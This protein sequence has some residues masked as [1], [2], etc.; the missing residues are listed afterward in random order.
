MSA[1]S[2]VQSGFTQAS[3]LAFQTSQS[4]IRLINEALVTINNYVPEYPT[5]RVTGTSTGVSSGGT[6]DPAGKPPN[7]PTIRD[8]AFPT[9]PSLGAL[10]N[11]DIEFDEQVPTLRIPSF[12]YRTPAEIDPFTEAFPTVDV[13]FTSVEAP[14][15][16]Y[17]DK[18][19][20]VTID[21]D[22]PIDPINVPDLILTKPVYDNQLTTD[23][24]IEFDAGWARIPHDLGN[25]ALSW[26]EKMF[27]GLTELFSLLKTRCSATLDGSETA[28]TDAFD[29]RLFDS[30]HT[31]IREDIDARRVALNDASRASGWDMPGAVRWAGE[32]SIDDTLL[33]ALNVAAREVYLKR[34][35]RELQHLQFVMGL[36][37][38]LFQS[39]TALFETAVGL[40]LRAFDSA[41]KFAD[42]STGFA[43]RVYELKQRELEAQIALMNAEITAFEALLKAQLAKVEVVK[44]R[45]DAEKLKADINTVLVQQYAAELG[46]EETKAKVYIAQINALKAELELRT[47]PVE[48]YKT[49]VEAYKVLVDAKRAEYALIDAQVAGDKAKMDG[50]LA[51][52]DIYKT[53]LEA[54]KTQ[55]E[56]ASQQ[57]NVQ[58]K[59]NEQTIDIYK[60]DIDAQLALVKT[61]EAQASHALDAYTAMARVF[62]AEQENRRESARQAFEFN[63][64]T[65]DL[66]LEQLKFDFQT[67][68]D[69]IKLEL[70]RINAITGLHLNAA[71]VEGAMAGSAMSAMNAIVSAATV[72]QE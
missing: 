9:R 7:F 64:K 50:E 16:S 62:I 38:Q 66:E 42:A 37:A 24:H 69:G 49:K 6:F 29:T 10:N 8:P 2:M 18:P 46:A 25:G 30:L 33:S 71:Q 52:L 34:A 35:E 51:K 55:I 47:L 43:L 27:P 59:R 45:L 1:E 36:C 72:Q 32:T 48:L 12:S 67:Q 53:Q 11:I 68:F 21:T 19:T 61:D 54:F 4:A 15:F 44:V 58:V 60:T 5:T 3:N 28:L 70:G 40:E 26:V 22:F 17:A 23:W 20:L 57:I 39:G 65:A 56:A 14:T 31:R 41:I 13:S 63:M